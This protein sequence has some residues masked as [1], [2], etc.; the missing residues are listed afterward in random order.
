MVSTRWRGGGQETAL[1]CVGL[2]IRFCHLRIT[3]PASPQPHLHPE[4]LVPTVL[5]LKPP[6][7]GPYYTLL[8]H[9]HLALEEE[10]K[11]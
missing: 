4:V 10:R 9:P 8:G 2:F 1:G 7:T 3:V 11:T 6:L 5:H